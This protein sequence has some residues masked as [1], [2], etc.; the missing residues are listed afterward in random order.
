MCSFVDFILL[1]CILLDLKQY[2][3]FAK[4]SILLALG[5]YNIYLL[6]KHVFEVLHDYDK[7][8]CIF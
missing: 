7:L 8:I 6:F 1:F 2:R 4:I 5:E 3:I